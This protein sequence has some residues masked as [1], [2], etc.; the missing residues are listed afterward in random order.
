[1]ADGDGDYYR[2]AF[3]YSRVEDRHKRFGADCADEGNFTT[4][5]S[6]EFAHDYYLLIFYFLSNNH[7]L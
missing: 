1:M 3:V 5:Y 6:T 4:L 2:R 7:I